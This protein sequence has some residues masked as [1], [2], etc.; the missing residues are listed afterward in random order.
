MLPRFDVKTE[1]EVVVTQSLAALGFD[2]VE[3][4]VKGSKRRP[5]FDVRI[6][7]EGG[8]AVSVND[9]AQVSRA[10]E[11]SLDALGEKLGDYVLEVS[12]PGVERS[13]RRPQDW[14]RFVGRSVSVLSPVLSGR[15]EM[16]L[17]GVE[18]EDGAEVALLR[19]KQGSDIR[20]PL[21]D[22]KEARLVF[23]WKR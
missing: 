13:L 21:A 5:V 16:E 11:T 8:E 12:S 4:M 20:V 17:L 23:H 10:L 14:K 2:L 9:C 6:E 1:L 3:L 22:V 19:N 15:H 18:G 7:K